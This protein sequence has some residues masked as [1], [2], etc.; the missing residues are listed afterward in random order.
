MKTISYRSKVQYDEQLHPLS[1]K[2]QPMHRR[3]KLPVGLKLLEA[4]KPPIVDANVAPLAVAR[5]SP[6]Q[7]QHNAL[8]HM[9]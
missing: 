1:S 9:Q 3:M 2:Q 8:Q 4:Q 6:N 5:P 7:R